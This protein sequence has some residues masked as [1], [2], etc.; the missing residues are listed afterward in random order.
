MRRLFRHMLCAL[1]GAMLATLMPGLAMAKDQ[2]AQAFVEAI[3]KPYANKDYKGADY[4]TPANLRRYFE[5]QLA[6][7][8]IKDMA[9]AAKR[10]EVSALDGDPFIDAQDWEI[11]DVTVETKTS[12]KAAISTVKFINL[13]VPK[14]VTLDLVKTP[15]GWR[16]ADI[17]AGSGSLRKLFKLK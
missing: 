8:M 10:K 5:P 7:A 17:N 15:A 14:T 12:G 6:N 3:Y 1:I 9:A 4:S 16:I 2:S 13:K 11:S